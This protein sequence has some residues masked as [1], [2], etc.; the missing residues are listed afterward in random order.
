M[1]VSGPFKVDSAHFGLTV[2]DA[3]KLAEVPK[4]WFMAEPTDAGEYVDGES[5]DPDVYFWKKWNHAGNSVWIDPGTSIG[6]LECVVSQLIPVD[7]HMVRQY[8]NTR[9]WVETNLTAKGF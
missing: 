4:P 1:T 6:H 3:K 9:E 2:I 7:G 8:F 5:T